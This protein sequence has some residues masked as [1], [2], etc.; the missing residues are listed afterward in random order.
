MKIFEGIIVSVGSSKTAVVEVTRR[1]PH[2]L[3]KKL[4][5]R[6]KKYLVDTGDFKI[7]VGN[8]IRMVETRPMSKNKFFR[9]SEITRALT[10]ADPIKKVEEEIKI[11]LEKKP[12]TKTIK[13]M[14]GETNS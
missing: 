12:K 14:K 6:S 2:P 10:L 1:T 4:I 5:K 13:K 11:V 3:Y 7:A 8:G 9:I